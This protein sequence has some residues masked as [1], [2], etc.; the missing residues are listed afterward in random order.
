[1]PVMD[2]TA[3]LSEIE[4][5][6]PQMKILHGGGYRKSEACRLSAAYPGA[7]FI[8]GPYSANQVFKVV[9]ELVG[10]AQ[11]QTGDKRPSTI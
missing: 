8:Q 1:M 9:A 6:R 11:L 10:A 2:A 5:R 3:L 7:A 4:A